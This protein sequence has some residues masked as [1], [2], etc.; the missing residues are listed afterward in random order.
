M[1]IDPSDVLA[2]AR[3][4][5]SQNKHQLALEKYQWFYRNALKHNEAYYGVRLS[6]CINEW[7]DLG[8]IYQPACD[9]LREEFNTSL[10]V[11]L[12]SDSR[13]AFHEYASIAESL[14]EEGKVYEQ[15]MLVHESNKELAFQLFRFVYTYCANN[16]Q[17]ELCREY[18]GD[19]YKQYSESLD[20]FDYMLEFAKQEGREF[21]LTTGQEHFKRDCL[22]LLNMLYCT[23]LLYTSPSPRDS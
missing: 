5:Y 17:W 23:C 14:G 15:F 18:L 22:W 11:F 8:K 3:D 16:N 4:A 7:A 13:R 2:E 12:Q 19:G 6:Y 20:M 9:A 1:E 10:K 21:A